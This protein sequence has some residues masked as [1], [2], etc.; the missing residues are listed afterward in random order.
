MLEVNLG[1]LLRKVTGTEGIQP[2]ELFNANKA[3]KSIIHC[4]KMIGTLESIL[5]KFYEESGICRPLGTHLKKAFDKD[6][7]KVLKQLCEIKAFRYIPGRKHKSFT[8]I[9][10]RILNKIR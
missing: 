6:F 4:G 2:N 9:I 5:E 10:M 8:H 7:D 1:I 3:Q